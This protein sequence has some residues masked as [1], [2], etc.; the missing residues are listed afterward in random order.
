MS[1]GE[2]FAG[3]FGRSPIK[4]IQQHFELCHQC[5]HKLTDFFNAA[6][7]QNWQQAKQARALIVELENQADEQKK[8]IRLKIPNSLF[9][10]IPR[11]ILFDLLNRQDKVANKAK[12]ISGLVLGRE[13]AIPV[14]I[15]PLFL[16]FLETCLATTTQAL[17]A[18]QELDELIET[19]FGQRAIQFLESLIDELD[20]L[21]HETDEIQIQLRKALLQIEDTLKPV[22]VIF[23]YKIIDWIGE[24]ADRAQK[25]GGQLQL[26]IAH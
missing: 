23:L 9:L 20:R 12:D 11:N 17:K 16:Q 21:E 1:L 13:M 15:K 5:A 7:D 24:L 25:V 2:S 26:I 19:G 10:P 3:L 14:E 22:E 4:P 6:I 8:Q 18:I